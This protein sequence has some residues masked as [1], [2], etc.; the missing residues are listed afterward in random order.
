LSKI[1]NHPSYQRIIAMGIKVVPL[2]LKELK[3]NPDHW[4]HALHKI[5]REN[6]TPKG[7]NFMEARK[8]WLEW[9]VKNNLLFL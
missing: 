4:F 1:I 7:S 6:P 9:G 3:E 8:A 2:I 5:T